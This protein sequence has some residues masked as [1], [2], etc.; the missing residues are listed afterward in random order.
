MPIPH[1]ATRAR[2]PFHIVLHGQDA[3]STLCYTGKMP[4]PHCATGT[5]GIIPDRCYT[6]LITEHHY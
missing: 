3:H 1:C 5:H 6:Y 4:I 2:C